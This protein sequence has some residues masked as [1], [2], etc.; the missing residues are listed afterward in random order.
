MFAEI[1]LGIATIIV[2][3]MVYIIRNLMIQNDTYQ[4]WVSVLTER[5]INMRIKL[6][7]IDNTGAFEA[8]DEVGYFFTELKNI[9][10]QLDNLGFVDEEVK[11]AVEAHERKLEEGHIGKNYGKITNED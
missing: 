2:G 10:D 5:V 7:T 11:Q 4:Q 9:F 3:G 1:L 8:D 6:H